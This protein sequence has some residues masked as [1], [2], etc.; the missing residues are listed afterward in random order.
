MHDEVSA[1]DS[2]RLG[3]SKLHD[4]PGHCNWV[5]PFENPFVR[6]MKRRIDMLF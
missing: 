6:R 1:A 3:A 2:E 5:K 4:V